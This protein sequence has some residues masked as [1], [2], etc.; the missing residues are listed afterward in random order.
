M[1]LTKSLF[2]CS[3]LFAVLH[4]D[5]GLI[6]NPWACL[7]RQTE[8]LTKSFLRVVLSLRMVSMPRIWKVDG[9]TCGEREQVA[10]E[11]GYGT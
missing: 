2:L 8:R 7:P 1:S 5:R 10:A 3:S 9:I 4:Y 11:Y 6:T